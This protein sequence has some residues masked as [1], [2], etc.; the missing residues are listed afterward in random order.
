MNPSEFADVIERLLARLAARS[1]AIVSPAERVNIRS[2]VGA[3][4]G[5]YKDAFVQMVGDEQLFALMD[6]FMQTILRRTLEKTA[7]RTVIREIR[8]AREYF[9]DTLLMPLSRAYWSRAPQKSPAGHDQQVASGLRQLDA[10]LADSYEQAVFDITDDERLSYRGP[11]AELR[12][13]LT[14]VL[15]IL[16]P[17]PRVQ[18]TDWYIE[19]RRSGARTEPTPTRAERVK[20]ILRNRMQGSAQTET[21]ETF[22]T[23]VEERLASVVN[24]TYKRGSAA[25]HGGTEQ[26][27]VQQI[28]QYINALLRELL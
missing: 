28:V 25:T 20:F 15:H 8:V 19:A 5:Q 6:A 12:E 14:G 17:N 9:N 27:E 7:R 16:A 11:A 22:M 18:E 2:F 24:A 10:D 1:S 3:W 23:T 4:F 26:V 13:V 21:A